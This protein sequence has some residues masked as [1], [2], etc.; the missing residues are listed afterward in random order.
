M[1]YD[2]I[3]SVYEKTNLIGTR[4]EQIAHGAVSTLSAEMLVGLRSAREIA[5]KEYE[6]GLIPM[7]IIRKMPNGDTVSVSLKDIVN[8]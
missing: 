5:M 6:M 8:K 2:Q 7:K 3:I 1:I 4:S